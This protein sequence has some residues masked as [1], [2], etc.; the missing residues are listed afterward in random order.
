MGG[1]RDGMRIPR[2]RNSSVQMQLP[3]HRSIWT[4]YEALAENG[5]P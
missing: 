5:K 4:I 1:G 2:K 3:L